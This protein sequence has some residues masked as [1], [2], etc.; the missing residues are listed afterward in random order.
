M[1]HPDGDPEPPS[2]PHEK[3]NPPTRPRVAQAAAPA[4]Q[5]GLGRRDRPSRLEVGMEAHCELALPLQLAQ[6]ATL[7]LGPLLGLDP[8]LRPDLVGRAAP[9]PVKRI[10]ERH[11]LGIPR[12]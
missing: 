12:I 4:W 1:S 10:Q 8:K 5:A 2:T 9:H 11:D 7:D 3:L 6:A